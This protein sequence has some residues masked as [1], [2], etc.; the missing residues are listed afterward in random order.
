MNEKL[1]DKPQHMSVADRNYRLY[2]KLLDEG[3]Y[4]VPVYRKSG[5]PKLTKAIDFL[6]VAVH[7]PGLDNPDDVLNPDFELISDN[8]GQSPG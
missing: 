5:D 3:L 2:K 8:Y 1:T 7:K 6:V 4:I